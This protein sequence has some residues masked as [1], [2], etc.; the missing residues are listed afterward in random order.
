MKIV[1]R[2]VFDQVLEQ[3]RL[4][5]S[6]EWCAP[7]NVSVLRFDDGISNENFLVEFRDQAEKFAFRM[8]GPGGNSGMV[9]RNDEKYNN[10]VGCELGITPEI[11]Y[12]NA[13]SGV[14]V[15]RFISDAET[16]HN[17]TIKQS[18]NLVKIATVMRR[19]HTSC[20][21][22]HKDF[23]PF[24]ELHRYEHLLKNVDGVMYDGY[25]Q[26]RERVYG[27]ENE[28]NKM[29]VQ[30]VPCHCDTLPENWLKDSAGKVWLL[31][32]EYSGM[33]DPFWDLT[34]PFIEA[35]FT[36]HQEKILLDAYF[37]G[38]VPYDAD[39]RVLIYKIIMDFIWAVWARVKELDG[40]DLRAY[41]LMRLARGIENVSKL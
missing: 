7:D 4:V 22:L 40:A 38:S 3:L 32:W 39:R 20:Y 41:G 31:D 10:M 1:T 37:D 9:D 13:K 5:F 11:L 17:D 26:Y 8:I 33:N 14:K 6:V 35:D 23:N 28:L 19:L 12:F 27:L 29:G 2:C 36:P 15:A 25:E 24:T 30:V 16:L 18:D 34:A 21:R